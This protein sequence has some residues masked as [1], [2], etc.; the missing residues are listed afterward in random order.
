MRTARRDA[1][2]VGR[3]LDVSPSPPRAARPED[4]GK[5]LLDSE[6]RAYECL[7]RVHIA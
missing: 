6:R 3:R 2:V 7:R 5:Y 1:S 4:M